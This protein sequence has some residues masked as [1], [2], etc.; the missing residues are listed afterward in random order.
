LRWGFLTQALV[1]LGVSTFVLNNQLLRE[2][3]AARSIAL[4]LLICLSCTYVALCLLARTVTVPVHDVAALTLAAFS[5][6]VTFRLA[7]P[8]YLSKRL[9]LMAH[10]A[11]IAAIMAQVT[12]AVAHLANVESPLV[13]AVELSILTANGLL[14]LVIARRAGLG[15][16]G[17]SHAVFNAAGS[18]DIPNLPAQGPMQWALVAVA[19]VLSG[20]A[21]NKKRG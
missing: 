13:A 12:F 17:A 20:K 6:E 15:P 3:A 18:V 5:E 1:F 7:L 2:F 11:V 14:L 19:S 10:G 21:G 9:S 16:A 4:H 8:G